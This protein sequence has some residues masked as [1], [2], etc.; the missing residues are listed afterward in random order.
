M[1]GRVN[2]TPEAQQQLHALDAWITGKASPDVAER[3]VA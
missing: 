1:T 3:F 2:Y